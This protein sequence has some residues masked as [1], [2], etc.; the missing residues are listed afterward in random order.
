MVK[1]L[2]NGRVFVEKSV[3]RGG[4]FE[5]TLA[6][7]DLTGYWRGI[8]AQM[9]DVVYCRALDGKGR[10]LVIQEIVSKQAA[11]IVCI[12]QPDTA[13]NFVSS[14][15]C[16]LMRETPNRQFPQFPVGLPSALE[17]IILS[18]FAVKA[19]ELLDNTEGSP[20]GSALPLTQDQI[21]GEE[22]I[23]AT[24]P[25]GKKAPVSLNVIMEWILTRP[26]PDASKKFRLDI[27]NWGTMDN[28]PKL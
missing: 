7:H 4:L 8:D 16:A 26:T 20:C 6:F 24:L 27:N 17:K 11:L 9:G 19:D 2:F 3:K 1:N 12:V 23:C 18:Y 15:F 5:L 25:N 22:M 13:L 28:K 21:T 14:E 10:R